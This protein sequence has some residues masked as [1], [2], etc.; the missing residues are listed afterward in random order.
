MQVPQFMPHGAIK[1]LSKDTE[2]IMVNKLSVFDA[3]FI[4]YYKVK[5]GQKLNQGDNLLCRNLMPYTVHVSISALFFYPRVLS[6]V[7][8]FISFW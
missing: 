1:D 4:P 2:V 6:P 8:F 5:F 3:G 7:L